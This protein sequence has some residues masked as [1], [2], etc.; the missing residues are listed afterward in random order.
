VQD[1]QSFLSPIF[2]RVQNLLTILPKELQAL[3]SDNILYIAINGGVVFFGFYFVSKWF[4]AYFLRLLFFIFGAWVLWQ[5][6]ARDSILQSFDFWA[7]LGLLLPQLEIPNLTYLIVKYRTLYIYNKIVELILILFNP[8]VWLYQ[9]LIRPIT[10]FKAKQEERADKKAYEKYY[11]EDFKQ[12]QKAEWE[13]EQ[14]RQDEQAQR[15]FRERESKR[16]QQKQE[17]HKKDEEQKKQHQEE[18]KQNQEKKTSSRWD[19][20]S[21]YVILGINENATKQEIKKAYRTLAKIYH[22]DLALLNKEEAEEIF[23][24]INEAYENLG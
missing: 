8:F 10:Y 16:K 22:P 17:Q 19:S 13:K 14:A 15:E 23:K 18:T 21:D 7:G 11:Q 9:L 20:N 3:T 4:R 2:Y 5:V 1:L 24:R 12:Q 6:S